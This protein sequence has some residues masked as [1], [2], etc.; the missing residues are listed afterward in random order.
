MKIIKL[1]QEH[2]H[3]IKPLFENKK[4]MGVDALG[5][6]IH[7]AADF[8]AT[9]HRLFCGSYLSDLKQYHAYAAVSDTMEV[10]CILAFYESNDNPEWYWT[11]IRSCGDKK[12]VQ[13]LLDKVIE[14]NENNGR[15]KFYSMWNMR[16]QH[17]YRKFAFSK[18][19]AERYDYFDEY[20]VPTKTKCVWNMPWLVLYGRTLV[21]ID[22]VV[23]CTFLKQQYRAKLDIAGN[24]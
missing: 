10:K 6:Y 4:F 17:I 12:S 14:H 23:R 9:Y 15:F 24:I 19:T 18:Y 22:T 5:N 21:P 11:H 7:A 2:L 16:Y 3:A 20:M 1:S 8:N 13:L